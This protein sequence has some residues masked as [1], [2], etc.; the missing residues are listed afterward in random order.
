[1]SRPQFKRILLKLSGEML[2][3]KGDKGVFDIA[4]CMELARHIKAVKE[5]GTELALVIGGGNIFRGGI[6]EELGIERVRSDHVGMLATVMNAMVM[7]MALEKQGVPAQALSAAAIGAVVPVYS[8]ARAEAEIEAGKVVIF[9][10]GT[11]NPY[12][13]T[14]TAAALRAVEIGADALLKGTKV[15]GIYSDDPFKNPEAEFFESISYDEVLNRGLKV[16]DQT[17]F[18]LCRENK[19]PIIVFDL[20]DLDNI[21]RVIAGEEIGTLVG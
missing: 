10:Y 17:A 5:S 13:T 21:K 8:H 9:C 20:G 12:F 3:G 4:L 2:K 19:L 11:G 14:D 15:K 6:A 16:M 18:A 1:M 7:Q